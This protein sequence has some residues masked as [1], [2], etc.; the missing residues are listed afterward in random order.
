MKFLERIETAKTAKRAHKTLRGPLRYAKRVFAFKVKSTR[1]K[2][3]PPPPKFM[4]PLCGH[5]YL[6]DLTQVKKKCVK[7]QKGQ[8]MDP[9]TK[10]LCVKAKENEV[11]RGPDVLTQWGCVHR[12]HPRAV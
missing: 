6:K 9:L 1:E 5:D 10:S 4:V 3:T 11:L 2:M 7:S 12:P 8:R